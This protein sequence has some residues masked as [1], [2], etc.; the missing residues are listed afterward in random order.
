MSIK[1]SYLNNNTSSSQGLNVTSSS[2]R[3]LLFSGDE[4][5]RQSH[6]PPPP[7]FFDGEKRGLGNGDS[8]NMSDWGGGRGLGGL[9]T[10]ETERDDARRHTAIPRGNPVA[11]R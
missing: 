5:S 2:Y 3:V 4:T 1:L 8:Q 9:H 11:A 10:V 6:F 7:R